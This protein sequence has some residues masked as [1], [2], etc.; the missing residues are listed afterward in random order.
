M[1]P[2]N[3][4]MMMLVMICT[5][6][7]ADAAPRRVGRLPDT[8]AGRCA[9]AFFEAY[10]AE[11]EQPLR[12]FEAKYR[13]KS[14]L[15]K[16]ATEDRIKQY[17]DLR[18]KWGKLTV[19]GVF[20]SKD[21]D[22]HIGVLAEKTDEFLRFRFELEPEPPHGLLAVTIRAGG[23][24]PRLAIRR[25]RPVDANARAVLVEDVANELTKSY[26]YADLG[27]KMAA[28]IRNNLADGAY[29]DLKAGD[30]FARELTEDLREICHDRHLTVM[31]ASTD[32]E[33]PEKQDRDTFWASDARRN[34]GFQKVERLP[35]NIG[36]VRLDEF[37][38]YDEAQEIAAAAMNFLTHTDALIF[39]LRNNGGGSPKMIAF[40][41]SYLFDK[42]THL[43]SFYNRRE[44]SRSETW[45]QADVPGSRYGEEK[46]VYVLT[47]SYTFSGAEEFTYNLKNLK[48]ATIVGET[49]GG[50]AHPVYRC[51]VGSGFSMMVPYAR[52]INPIT[53]T[54]WE[55]TGVT[56]HIKAHTDQALLFA[57][58]DAL[59]K[60]IATADDEE[61]KAAFARGLKRVEMELARLEG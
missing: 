56:P 30:A 7:P 26:V 24:R 5:A 22:I 44:D 31:A 55:G 14:A 21:Y 18:G 37:S 23:P 33:A 53:K 9:T 13:A 32:E 52:A 58:R 10:N 38:S 36:Y 43:N 6:G 15:A 3:L 27:K 41:S 4:A 34:Y 42:P 29:D 39:D 35:G 46:P 59:Q 61:A 2:K 8:E 60:L 28:A 16:R 49:T 11:G 17:K 51:S 50:G 57:Q 20:L 40:L 19:D 48:R 25:T 54:N 1:Q 47:S 12:A 45:T